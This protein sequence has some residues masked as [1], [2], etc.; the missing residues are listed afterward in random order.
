MSRSANLARGWKSTRTS[1]TVAAMMSAWPPV[2]E[3]TSWPY[4]QNLGFENDCWSRVAEGTKEQ[5]FGL[6]WR[7]HHCHFEAGSPQEV[8]LDGVNIRSFDQP[9]QPYLW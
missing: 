1:C 8:A 5:T 3:T 4:S 2:N 9:T 6:D 7:A